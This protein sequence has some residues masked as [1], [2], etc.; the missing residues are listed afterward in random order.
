MM[1]SIADLAADVRAGARLSP[2][3]PAS[4]PG[5]AAVAMPRTAIDRDR[6]TLDCHG[7]VIHPGD[8]I[9]FHVPG[10]ALSVY[11]GRYL[12]RDNMGR[13]RARIDPGEPKSGEIVVI[14]S[15]AVRRVRD[16]DI[17]KDVRAYMAVE[18]LRLAGMV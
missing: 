2:R 3:G 11:L 6:P 7:S 5:I 4:L 8:P 16:D 12:D 10:S 9:L 18:I 15:K 13:I 14:S 17:L 1:K